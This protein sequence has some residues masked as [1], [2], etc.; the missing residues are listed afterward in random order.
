MAKQTGFFRW[1]LLI[2]PLILLGGVGYYYKNKNQVV[3]VEIDTVQRR[4]IISKVSESGTIEPDIELPIS[5][6]VSGEIITLTVKEGD[7]VKR[8]QLLFEIKPDNYKAALEQA[9]AALNTA[10]ADLANASATVEQAKANLLQDSVSYQRNKLL[11]EQKVIAKA[12][13]ETFELKYNLSK[14]ALEAANQAKT[15]AFFRVQS[16]EASL[17]QA[18]ENLGKTSI[19]AA[20]D[21]IITKI[22]AE[23][24]QRV[25]GTAQMAG[26]EVMK[27]ADLT[28]MQVKVDINESDIIQI[29][30]GDTATIEVDAYNG[31]LF[32]G[33]VT[34]LAYSANVTAA[35]S[36]DQ[37]TSYPV[38]VL[39]SPESYLNDPEVMNGVPPH[40]SPFRPGMSALVNIYTNKEENVLSV[41]IQ[42]V[43]VST[44]EKNERG[45][46]Q[47]IVFLY[48]NN[49]VKVAKVKSSISDER[50]IKVE[51]LQEKQTV[52]SGP[53]TVVNKILK[54]GMEVRLKEKKDSKTNLEK[55]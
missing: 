47:E 14:A 16:A 55:K 8:G 2:I 46:S 22:N 33:V 34:E 51:G 26:T 5:P 50:Y 30:P 52:V 37:I 28:R 15:A 19:Y 3:E 1:W 20:M 10:R 42:A 29:Q 54:D 21:G 27:I 44:E 36:Q 24:G 49:K 43:T 40:Q 18:K 13:L 4:T 35:G 9:T 12:E 7:F 48:E 45:K 31:K 11:F 41:P 32:R 17:K 23:K 6:E 39:I 25:V 38:R 53:Y